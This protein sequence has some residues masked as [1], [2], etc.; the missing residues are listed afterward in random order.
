V[1]ASGSGVLADR[2]DWVTFFVLT[3]ALAARPAPA[4]LPAPAR[5]RRNDGAAGSLLG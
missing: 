3:T 5:R 4:R 1:L 2:T